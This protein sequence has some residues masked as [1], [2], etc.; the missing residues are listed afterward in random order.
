VTWSM[1]HPRSIRVGGIVVCGGKS[2]RMGRAKAW[3][4][5]GRETFLQ[6]VVRVLG[7]VVSPVVVVAAVGQELPPLP[8]DVEIVR[9]EFEGKGP[10][11]GL[12]TGLGALRGRCDAA[13]ASSTDVP[14]LRGSFVC[15]VIDELGE[16]D[17]VLPREGKFHH[18][19]AGCYRVSL[20]P[21]VRGLVERDRLRPVFLLDEA[22]G[23]EVD[24]ERLRV[25][26]PELDSLRNCNTPEEY[27]EMLRRWDFLGGH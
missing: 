21:V 22:R 12:T 24:V 26:D 1:L 6:R 7:E 10:L 2:S 4:E 20:E 14:L 13:Y 8:D 19:L 15:A 9:D 27:A 18:P 11:A 5:L 3:L 16:A 17:F 23:V 25:A